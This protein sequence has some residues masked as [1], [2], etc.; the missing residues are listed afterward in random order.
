MDGSG[1]DREPSRHRHRPG[2]SPLRER[3]VARTHRVLVV[4]DESS[5]RLLCTV[6]LM[7]AGFEVEEAENGVE[8]LER[9]AA[10]PFDLVL[11]DVM[12]PDVGGHE[13]ARRLA[14]DER[15]RDVPVVFVSARAERSDLWAGYAAG[16]VD[17]IPKPFDPVALGD[18]V[19]AILARLERGEGEAFRLARLRELEERGSR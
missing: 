10:A 7:L 2:E 8:A 13:V 1:P 16:G 18:R 11:L 9:A 15:T 5:M 17:Y 3:E 14:A 12:L 19:A 6:N 4:D